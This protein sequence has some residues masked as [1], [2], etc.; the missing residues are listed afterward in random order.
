MPIKPM[1]LN[2]VRPAASPQ[3]PPRAPNPAG[4]PWLDRKPERDC[5]SDLLVAILLLGVLS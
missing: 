1:P 3:P 4:C 5:S 2:Q